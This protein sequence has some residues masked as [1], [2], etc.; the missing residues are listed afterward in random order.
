VKPVQGDGLQGDG[1]ERRLNLHMDQ[2]ALAGVYSNFAN[3]SFSDFEFTLTF[4]RVEFES[5]QPELPGVVVSRVNLSAP[6]MARFVDAVNDA[7]SKW[8]TREGIKNLPE[9]PPRPDQP[10]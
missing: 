4:G 10:R 2:E 5:E 7:W 1:D 6:F 9:A 8:Q 3:V